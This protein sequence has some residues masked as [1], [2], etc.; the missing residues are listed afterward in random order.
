MG[1]IQKISL[2]HYLNSFL[3]KFIFVGTVSLVS[4]TLPQYCDVL[5]LQKAWDFTH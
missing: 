2:I 5:A 4:Q 1:E 3:C